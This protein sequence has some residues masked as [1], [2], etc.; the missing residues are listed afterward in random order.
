MKVFRCPHC[1]SVPNVIYLIRHRSCDYCDTDLTL[2]IQEIYNQ[3]YRPPSVEA[4]T[5]LRIAESHL[6][7]ESWEAAIS[8]AK[9]VLALVP[10]FPIAYLYIFMARHRAISLSQLSC[11]TI[12][13]PDPY[14]DLFRRSAHP[15][16]RAEVDCFVYSHDRCDD[17]HCP[18]PEYEDWDCEDVYFNREPGMIF[19]HLLRVALASGLVAGGILILSHFI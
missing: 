4:T 19:I 14:Y 2:E 16:L 10:D 13:H 6:H 5:L 3:L 9:A 8:Y 15:L 1:E 7:A 11:R 17:V 12:L 18:D